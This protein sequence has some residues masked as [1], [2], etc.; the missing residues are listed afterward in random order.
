MPLLAAAGAEA[1]AAAS[2]LQPHFLQNLAL[3]GNSSPHCTQSMGTPSKTG[4]PLQTAHHIS[5]QCQFHYPFPDRMMPAVAAHAGKSRARYWVDPQ[6]QR[7]SR[8]GARICPSAAFKEF[9]SLYRCCQIHYDAAPF[10]LLAACRHGL[11]SGL[12]L[13]RPCPN[14]FSP[15]GAKCVPAPM[16]LSRPMSVCPG[17]KPRSWGC[18]MSS[19][20][21][22]L[23]F[24]R[25]S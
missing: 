15:A 18:S 5:F 19:P 25:R 6:L 9:P 7:Q 16:M 4:M 23:P 2:T 24:W 20:C 11:C 1:G 12:P 13:H 17:R 21:S 3:A 8:P 10:L 14:P 22:A